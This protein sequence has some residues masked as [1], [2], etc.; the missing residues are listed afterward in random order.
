MLSYEQKK[1]IYQSLPT[2]ILEE[3]GYTTDKEVSIRYANQ[4]T[5]DT[6]KKSIYPVITLNYINDNVVVNPILKGDHKVEKHLIENEEKHRDE[7]NILDWTGVESIKKVYTKTETYEEGDDYEFNEDENK[8]EWGNG[9]TPSG[10]Y[11]VDYYIKMVFIE[12]TEIVQDTLD[13]NVYVRESIDGTP[14]VVVADEIA[15]YLYRH[16]LHFKLDGLKAVGRTEINDLTELDTAK[17]WKQRRQFHVELK[18][19][20]HVEAVVS[21][22]IAEVEYGLDDL[23]LD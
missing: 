19:T 22:T 9:S 17:L 3:L 7:D 13:I 2:N 18:H 11:Y 14:A 15:R 20:E 23:E 1:S 21:P 10:E 5:V 6:D 4:F 8:I 16:F 12:V